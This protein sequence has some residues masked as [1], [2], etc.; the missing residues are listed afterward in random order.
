MLLLYQL[1]IH[2]QLLMY[3]SGIHKVSRDKRIHS[4]TGLQTR[5][6]FW[7][8]SAVHCCDRARQGESNRLNNRN[9]NAATAL[10]NHDWIACATV[11]VSSDLLSATFAST[12][13]VETIASFAVNPE[14]EAATG[15]HSPNP[16]GAKIGAINPP[17]TASKL[18]ALSSTS[19]NP[20][21]VK[22]ESTKEPHYY[23]SKEQDGSGFDDK[24]FQSLPYM[25]K[26]CLSLW[27]MI[28]WKLHNEWC[29][30]S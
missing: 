11:T 26:N 12:P 4:G 15:C 30:F 22:S 6:I 13:I 27:N 24:A 28:L 25:K 20:P 29:R 3:Q 10:G 2:L 14:R 16:S 9:E 18:S 17:I 19:P 23:T 21:F 1:Q 7:T 5:T 8:A